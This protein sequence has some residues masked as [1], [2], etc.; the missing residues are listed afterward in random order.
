MEAGMSQ[1]LLRKIDETQSLINDMA[2]IRLW[3]LDF[4]KTR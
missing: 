4:P 3:R 2:H 1:E